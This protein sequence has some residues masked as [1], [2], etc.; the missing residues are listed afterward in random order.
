MSHPMTIALAPSTNTDVQTGDVAVLGR[1][2]TLTFN[3]ADGEDATFPLGHALR[4]TVK[5]LCDHDAS[6]VA[7]ATMTRVTDTQ[8]TVSWALTTD[9]YYNFMKAVN[10]KAIGYS[11]TDV[12][13]GGTIITSSFLITNSYYRPDDTPPEGTA[14]H[15]LT[16]PEIE[17]LIADLTAGITAAVSAH[18]ASGTAHAALFAATVTRATA[19]GEVLADANR[20]EVG[21]YIAD[22]WVY[23]VKTGTQLLAYIKVYT[24]TLYEAVNTA[25]LKSLG[26][27][28]G[29]T[30]RWSASGVPE[31][32][33]CLV[34][35]DEAG[36]G[37]WA[38]ALTPG[39]FHTVVR[40]G[41]WTGITPSGLEIGE[42]CSGIITG[43]YEAT[44]TGV[45]A[46]GEG[47][48]TDIAAAIVVWTIQRRP[49]GYYMN[50]WEVSA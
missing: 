21:Q 10:Q 28:A 32:S 7:T 45:I 13:N 11:I 20:F 23:C 2:M 27:T 47:A 17:A 35:L 15:S 31:R 44:T 4:L 6:P 39:A 24:D 19:D 22:A 41:I 3:I 49:N 43:L 34:A 18:N 12:T 30:L 36:A 1:T 16:D 33:P 37:D 42:G 38:P 29:D 26:T 46:D 14:S 8:A 50:C 40:S 48:L 25:I 5:K 9:V